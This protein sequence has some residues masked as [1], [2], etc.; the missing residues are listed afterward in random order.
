MKIKIYPDP[1]LRKKTKEITGEDIEKLNQELVTGMI[2]YGGI[3]LAAPQIGI[4]KSIAIISEKVDKKLNKPLFLINPKIE[5]Y[6]GSQSI[7]E[8]CLSVRGVNEYIP[9][10]YEIKVETGLENDRKII[11]AKDLLAIVIQHEVD[12]LNGILFPDRLRFAKRLWC[13]F[14]ARLSRKNEKET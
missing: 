7:E 5:E 2:N 10:A 9:R 4:D 12:H 3:G 1:I 13:L 6:S 14:R 8:G 11:Y